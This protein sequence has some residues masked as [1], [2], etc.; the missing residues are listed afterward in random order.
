[1][2][3]LVNENAKLP[4]SCTQ[5]RLKNE[6]WGNNAKKLMSCGELQNKETSRQNI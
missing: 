1:M 5:N 2:V 3:L 4:A 6:T